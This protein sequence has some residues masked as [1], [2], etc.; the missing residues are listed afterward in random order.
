MYPI[1]ASPEQLKLV[2][3]A[4]TVKNPFTVDKNPFKFPFLDL[5]FQK[6]GMNKRGLIILMM[7]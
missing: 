2:L 4:Y 7:K 6:S 3:L 1:T 5:S